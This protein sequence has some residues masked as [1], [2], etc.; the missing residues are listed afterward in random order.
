M[1]RPAPR[2]FYFGYGSLVNRRTRAAEEVA[3]PATLHGWIRQWSHQ[4]RRPWQRPNAH[5]AVAEQSG[6]GVCAVS[7]EQRDHSA[8]DGVLGADQ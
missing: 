7:V 1:S 3:I 4:A 8:I 5:H 6:H 2:S